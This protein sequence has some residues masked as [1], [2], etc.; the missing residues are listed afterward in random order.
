MR[1]EIRDFNESLTR[2]VAL[3]EGLDARALERVYEERLQ[4]SLGR[5]AD[6]GR[7]K[8]AGLKTLLVSGGFNFFTEA[9]ARL[10]LDFARQYA[11]IVDGKLTG[12]VLGEIVNADVERARCARPA[13]N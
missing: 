11:E 7:R 13:G 1:G 6:A 3:P 12:K 8:E 5:R 10:G 2:R 4:L 9:K